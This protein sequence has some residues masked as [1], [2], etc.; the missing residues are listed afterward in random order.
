MIVKKKNQRQTYYDLFDILSLNY[1]ETC[2]TTIFAHILSSNAKD[3]N[4][5]MQLVVDCFRIFYLVDYSY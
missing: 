5:V 2:L 3:I 1:K 4:I